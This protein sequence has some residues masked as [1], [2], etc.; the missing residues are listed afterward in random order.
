MFRVADLVKGVNQGTFPVGLQCDVEFDHRPGGRVADTLP[1]G[2]NRIPGVL[3]QHL[4][5]VDYGGRREV[6]E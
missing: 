2:R 1:V 3:D 5:P 6:C 4:I